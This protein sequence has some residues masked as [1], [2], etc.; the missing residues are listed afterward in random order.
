M[1][2]STLNW[3]DLI[4]TEKKHQTVTIN[5]DHCA[6]S[7]VYSL[8]MIKSE[9]YIFKNI[10]TIFKWQNKCRRDTIIL[11][12]MSAITSASTW[13]RK[14]VLFLMVLG[15]WN[16]V[17][18]FILLTFIYSSLTFK[19]WKKLKIFQGFFSTFKLK[20]VIFEVFDT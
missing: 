15:I 1:I 2:K 3:L 12:F 16:K 20:S 10:F 7:V 4:F 17:E 8:L 13:V 6:F 19:N 5:K 18:K 9:A 14:T 11:L